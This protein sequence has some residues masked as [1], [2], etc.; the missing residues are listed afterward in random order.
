MFNFRKPFYFESHILNIEGGKKMSRQNKD[1]IYIPMMV[2]S[3][4]VL[5]HKNDELEFKAIGLPYKG[6]KFVTYFVL[7]EP[8][9]TLR[10]LVEKMNGDILKNITK[11]TNLTEFTYFVPKM[12]L[13]SF[14]NLRPV[15]QVNIFI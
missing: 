6:K 14:T 3:S 15:L 12:T 2:G 7:P 9:V 1:Y 5:Y 10:S 8:N 13:E 11:Y 4:E